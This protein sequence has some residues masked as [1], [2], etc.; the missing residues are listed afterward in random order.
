MLQLNDIDKT[1]LSAPVMAF[2]N[3]LELKH[4]KVPY[5]LVVN[6]VQSTHRPEHWQL[7]FHDARFADDETVDLAGVVEWT[8]GNRSEKEYKV[9]SRKV[10]N[11]RYGHWGNEH[12]S[13]RTKDVKKA[14]K[15]AMD[16]LQPFEWHEISAKGRRNAEQSHQ[17]WL[18]EAGTATHPFHMGYD[19]LYEEIKH[20]VEQGVVFKTEK[21]KKAAAGIPAYEEFQE[22][23]SKNARFHTVIERGEKVIYIKDG[24]AL[25]PEEFCAIDPLP[26][27]TRN[28]IALLKLV[29]KEKLLPD[30]GYRHGENTYFVYV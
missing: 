23:R 28:A 17:A 20:L 15:I 25:E 9:T 8:Y 4:A 3:A 7:R 29:G 10:Q 6:A 27:A 12:S 1:K 13:R 30:V 18:N 11:D 19:V 16:V 24:H 22:R 14:V 26:E 21:F 5:Y 2:L